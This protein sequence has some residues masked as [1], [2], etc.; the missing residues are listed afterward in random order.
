MK[1]NLKLLTDQANEL[2]KLLYEKYGSQ[3][4][5]PDWAEGLMNLLC[6][7]ENTLTVC[8]EVTIEKTEEE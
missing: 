4:P 8:D 2:G 6:S 1:V 5:R 7:L 3:R